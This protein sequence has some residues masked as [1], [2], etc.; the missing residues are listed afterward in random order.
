MPR[1]IEK[2]LPLCPAFP[3]KCS[4]LYCSSSSQLE[5]RSELEPELSLDIGSELPLDSEDWLASVQ[6][7]STSLA[8]CPLDTS[9]IRR[10]GGGGGGVLLW[11]SAVPIHPWTPGCPLAGSLTRRE[12][13]TTL[14]LP[15]PMLS[16]LGLGGGD[17]QYSPRLGLIIDSSLVR[18]IGSP[19][20]P[21]CVTFRL[22]VAPLRG[23]GQPPVLPFACC[24][25]LLLSVGRCGRC[26]CWCRFRVHGAQ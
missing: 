8:S 18:P 23:P 9:S 6:L 19:P 1:L 20:P 26:S 17:L 22:V 4:P 3:Q 14:A 2:V 25:G 7:L 10:G 15:F 24:V 16:P 21:P 11:L 5:F 13:I 12:H